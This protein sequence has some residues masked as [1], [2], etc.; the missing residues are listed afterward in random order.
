[1]VVRCSA[2][3]EHRP[4]TRHPATARPPPEG[5]RTDPPD[6][7]ADRQLPD[8]GGAR[9]ARRFRA[10]PVRGAA[11]PA[12]PTTRSARSKDT[13]VVSVDGQDR[14]RPT[15][16]LRMTTV[17]LTDDVT[18]FGALG[19]WVSGRYALAPRDEF[20]KPGES[21]E[22]GRSENNESAFRTRRPP[23]RSPRCATSVSGHGDREPRSPR[24]AP[25]TTSSS[26]AT[27][28][29]GQRQ[30]D[31]RA[32]TT[33]AARWRTPSPGDRIEVSFE[34]DGTSRSRPSSP[35]GPATTAARRASSASRRSTAPTSPS[36][37]RSAW[38]TS[39]ARRPA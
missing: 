17:S 5:A 34:K 27:A 10:G 37:S 39:A 16:S 7:D 33:C 31:R 2:V 15:G 35:L 11:A 32:P 3:S 20:F 18:L 36:R 25:R 13:D 24:A 22:R 14:S 21:E 30:A 6:V 19:L 26:P 4:R 29:R 9:A 1:M 38:P 8:R 12:R 28:D 23:P